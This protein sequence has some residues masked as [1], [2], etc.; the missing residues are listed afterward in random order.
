MKFVTRTPLLVTAALLGFAA[1]SPAADPGESY[2][3]AHALCDA[4]LK[5]VQAGHPDVAVGKL[6][7]AQALI[8]KIS[9]S[10]PQWQPALVAYRLQKIENLLKE[11]DPS[12]ALSQEVLPAPQTTAVSPETDD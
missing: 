1:V 12:P 9:Q 2:Q 3:R 5:E 11:L 4:G 10:Q 6:R 8:Q 7:A